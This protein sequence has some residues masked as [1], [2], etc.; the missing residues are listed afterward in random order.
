VSIIGYSIAGII[1]NDMYK[2]GIKRTLPALA[3]VLVV[4]ELIILV[5]QQLG[6]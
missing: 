3:I 1:A 2:Q 5:Y 6:A 4:L